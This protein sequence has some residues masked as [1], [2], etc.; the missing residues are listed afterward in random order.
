[1]Y[2][3]VLSE[4]DWAGVSVSEV[5]ALSHATVTVTRRP[6]GSPSV[7]G[8]QLMSYDTPECMGCQSNTLD[9]HAPDPVARPKRLASTSRIP[10]R[11]PNLTHIPSTQTPYTLT[12][13]FTVAKHPTLLDMPILDLSF[14]TGHVQLMQAVVSQDQGLAAQPVP[15]VLGDKSWPTSDVGWR[16]DSWK[17]ASCWGLE[18]R[19]RRRIEFNIWGAARPL[20]G[21]EACWGAV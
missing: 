4:S 15:R 20:V 7:Y 18:P 17:E 9:E 10:S 16:G 3:M 19:G 12:R 13:N 21:G 6:P 8:G 14:A 1:M 11:P 5:P 2:N